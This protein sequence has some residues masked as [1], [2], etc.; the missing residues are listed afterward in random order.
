MTTKTQTP[1]EPLQRRALSGVKVGVVSADQRDKTRTVM[2]SYQMRHPKYGKI[3]ARKTKYHVHDPKNDSKSGDVVEIV[4]CR[5]VSKTKQWRL[6]RVIEK[7]K[8]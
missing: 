7:G 3:I 1:G 8:D 5:P 2:V 6:V 4:N